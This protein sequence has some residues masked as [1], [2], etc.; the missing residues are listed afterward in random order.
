MDKV[1]QIYDGILEFIQ[2]FLIKYEYENR[3]ILKKMKIDNRLN[4]DIDDEKWCKLFLYKSCLNHCAKLILLRYIEDSGLCYMKMNKNGI[5]KWKKLVKNISEKFNILYDIAIKDLQKDTDNKIRKIFKQSDYDIF[6]I[7]DELAAII[8]HN[9]SGLDF[10]TLS[11]EDVVS[12][13][14]LI[15]SLEQREDMRLDKFYKVAPALSYI[16]NLEELEQLL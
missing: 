3:G 7:D 9:L 8:C 14:K 5:E 10:A 11:K 4:M 1:K 13:F 16:L 2:V 15:Y 12:I 6:E